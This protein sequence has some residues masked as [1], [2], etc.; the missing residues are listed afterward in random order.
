MTIDDIRSNIKKGCTFTTAVWERPLETKSEFKAFTVVKRTK[1]TSLLFGADYDKLKSTANLR[2]IGAIPEKITPR[3]WGTWTM[4]PYIL[5]HTKKTGEHNYYLQFYPTVNTKYKVEYF[6]N[7]KPATKE[8]ALSL[9]RKQSDEKSNV[10][11]VTLNNIIA[12]K[13]YQNLVI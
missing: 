13:M 2:S 1:A 11:T 3:K 6:V 10:F 5:E 7:G 8:Y 12:M 9:C 4:F